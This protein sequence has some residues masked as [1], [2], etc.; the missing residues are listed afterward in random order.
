MREYERLYVTFHYILQIKKEQK[1][2]QD[3]ARTCELK[4]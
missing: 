1:K 3:D 4:R 2:K